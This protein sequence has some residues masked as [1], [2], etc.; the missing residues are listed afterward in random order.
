MVCPV[1]ILLVLMDDLLGVPT[2]YAFYQDVEE[3]RVGISPVAVVRFPDRWRRKLLGEKLF[4][5]VSLGSSSPVPLGY[6]P[7]ARLPVP[8][9]VI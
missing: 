8:C 2:G 4:N 7:L 9:H 3:E 6:Q 5:P 1:R